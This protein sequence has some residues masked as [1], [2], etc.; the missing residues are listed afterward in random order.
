MLAVTGAVVVSTVIVAA[1]GTQDPEAVRALTEALPGEAHGMVC[2]DAHGARAPCEFDGL[3]LRRFPDGSVVLTLLHPDHDPREASSMHIYV[4]P[5]PRVA[6][7]GQAL[8]GLRVGQDYL[9]RRLEVLES[10][11]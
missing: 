6:E 1:L 11:R 9:A 10:R 3:Q 7:L 2:R 4:P 5:D 8:A